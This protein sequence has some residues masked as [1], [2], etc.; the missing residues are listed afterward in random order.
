MGYSNNSKSYRVYHL[1]TRR[2]MES[3]NVIFIETPSRRFP[4]QLEATSQQ[5]IPPSNGMHDHN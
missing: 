4:P 1:A 5:I 3:W 2:I